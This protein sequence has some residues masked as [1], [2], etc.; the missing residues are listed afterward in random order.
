MKIPSEKALF[1]LVLLILNATFSSAQ[2]TIY[3]FAGISGTNE[4]P[5]GANSALASGDFTLAG[6]NLAYNV[7]SFVS[8]LPGESGVYGPAAPGGVASLIFG[9]GAPQYWTADPPCTQAGSSFTGSTNLTPDQTADLKAGL[10]YVDLGSI[11]G[12]ITI[13]NP[14]TIV[15]QPPAYITLFAGGPPNGALTAYAWGTQPLSYIWVK[16][17]NTVAEGT[18]CIPPSTSDAGVYQLIVSNAFGSV[19]SSMAVVSMYSNGLTPANLHIVAHVSPTNAGTVLGE[20]DY[21]SG[22]GVSLWAVPNPNFKFVN[23]VSASSGKVVGTNPVYTSIVKSS[24]TFTAK[25]AVIDEEITTTSAP[26]HAGV[27][28]GGGKIAYGTTAK[29]D[30]MPASGYAFSSWSANGTIVSLSLNYKFTVYT[31]ETL[32]ANFVPNPFVP[33]EGTY[34]GLFAPTNEPRRQTNSGAIK[35]NVSKTGLLSGKLAIGTDTPSL[36]GQFNAGGFATITAARKGQSTL[37]ITLQLDFTNQSVRGTVEDGSFLANLTGDKDVFSGNRTTNQYGG[38]YTM[39]IAGV[40]AATEGPYGTSYGTLTVAASGAITFAGSLAD[41]TKVTQN[42]AISQDGR[43]PF[44]LPL[45]GGNGSI[46][47]WN[48]FTNGGIDSPTGLSWISSSN[49]AKAALYRT[50][51]TNQSAFIIGSRYDPDQIPLLALTNGLVILDGGNVSAITN[52]FTLSS[53]NVVILTNGA[54]TNAS[55]LEIAKSTGIISGSFS[56]P[57]NSKATIKLNGVLLQDETNGYGYF[58]GTNQSGAFRLDPQ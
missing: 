35:F 54:A 21:T 45:Y 56:N 30:A 12:Q 13:S 16:G 27:T 22:S 57:F 3:L 53:K 15:Q 28:R 14:P 7:Y 42:S 46:W 51:F 18:C 37:T 32:T 44:Y 36:S 29:L 5:P 11:R 50:G 40:E 49:T 31:N 58:L 25:F 41:G 33:A 24:E 1:V 34:Y 19:T 20:G 10:C 47:G 43:W 8:G 2:D 38:R 48:Y 4:V 6:N 55:K 23:W 39:V 17:S 26:A 9:M 52:E